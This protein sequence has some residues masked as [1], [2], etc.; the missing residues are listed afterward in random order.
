MTVHAE[1][2]DLEGVAG[3]SIVEFTPNFLLQPVDF[4][5]KELNGTAA[6][7]AYH[8]VV[9]A[10]IVLVFKTGLAVMEFDFTGQATFGE[11]LQRAVDGSHAN[12]RVPGLDQA[13]KFVGR[14]MVPGLQKGLQDG[15]ALVGLLQSYAFQV[16]AEDILSLA[17]HFGRDDG[18]VVDAFVRHGL[19]QSYL[20][21][22]KR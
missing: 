22:C 2:I 10:A 7:G 20:Q 8:V 12:P 16:L 11:E 18:M 21:S 1:P 17:Q 4:R 9:A 15:I 19:S 3:G 14:K 5:G 6:S 13:V